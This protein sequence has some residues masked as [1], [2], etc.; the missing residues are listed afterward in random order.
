[1]WNQLPGE[2]LRFWQDFR[3]TISKKPLGEAV[4]DTQHLWSYAPYVAHYLT[5]D[6]IEEWP[7]P[8]ELVYENYY[9]DLAKALGI[10][11]TLYLSDHKPELEIRLYNEPSTKEQYNLVFVDNEK[12]VLN[13]IHDEVVNKKQVDSGLKLVRTISPKDLGLEKLQ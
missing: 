8:W 7:G 5:T 3:K 10:V 13:Y 9:C 6:H 12:Y 11:Y 1:M 2:R 4:K